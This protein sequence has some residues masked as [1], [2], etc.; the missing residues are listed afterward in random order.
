VKWD[1]N[2]IAI[3][4][5]P[6]G[7]EPADIG[8]G[9]PQPDSWG[10]AMARWPAASCDPFNFFQD[11]HVIFDTTLWYVVC[12]QPSPKRKLRF[13]YQVAIGLRVYGHRLEFLDKT[14]AA[15]REPVLPRAKT[16]YE[17]VDLLSVKLVRVLYF[18]SS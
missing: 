16:L 11:H 3:Y 13:V 5:F 8:A 10:S 7:S 2:G 15:L 9:K 18:G 12:S 14:R 17:R 4:F 1:S 6:R